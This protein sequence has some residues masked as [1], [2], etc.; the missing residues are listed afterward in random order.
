MAMTASLASSRLERLDVDHIADCG[1]PDLFGTLPDA[2]FYHHPDWFLAADEYLLSP[3]LE[4]FS[5]EREGQLIALLP[6]Q[7]RLRH[8]RFSTA[9]H[10]HLSL[11]D[12]LLHPALDSTEQETAIDC[13]LTCARD[14]SWDWQIRNLPDH[15]LLNS[16]IAGRQGSKAHWET[17]QARQSAWFD[18]QAGPLPAGGKL[19]RNLKRLRSKLED[20]GTVRV[21][22][23]EQPH[24]LLQALQHF[25]MLEAAGWKGHTGLSTAIAADAKL[26]GFYRRL[27]SPRFSGLQAVITLLWL[28]DTCIA[29]QYGLRTGDC[30]SLLKIAYSERHGH[31]SPGSL[32]LQYSAENATLSG[33]RTL[34]LV[35][36]PPWA[37][38]WHPLIEPVWHV[39]RFA[40][41]TGGLA[42]RTLYRLKQ[43]ARVHLRLAA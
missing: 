3:R 38:R 28:D 15:A 16:T 10:D 43:A 30:L 31:F 7:A 34:N 4:V 20:A 18:L 37:D 27:L 36:S 42:L 9:V 8:H 1:W 12:I 5:V 13:A 35:T 40:N 39:T 41:N 33:I 26:T 24:E 11:G 29:A 17:R 19:R 23:I 25:L 2:R 32:L 14:S 21:D 22:W 6:L